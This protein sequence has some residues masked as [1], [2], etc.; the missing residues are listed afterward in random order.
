MDGTEGM[1]DETIALLRELYQTA[2]W[3][4]TRQLEFF[5][6]VSGTTLKRLEEEGQKIEAILTKLNHGKDP[7]CHEDAVS[8]MAATAKLLMGT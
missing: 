5:D 6:H 1:S 7:I 3:F 2:I 4:R 8:N